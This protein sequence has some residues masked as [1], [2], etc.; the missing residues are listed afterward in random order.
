MDHYHRWQEDVALMREIGL[1]A[2]RMSIAWSRV[3]P[4]GKGALNPKGIAYYDRLIDA[5]LDA[6]IRP[7]VTL[8]HYDIPQVLE[9]QGGWWNR[10]LTNWFAEYAGQMAWLYGDRVTH[11]MTINRGRKILE[12]IFDFELRDR[13]GKKGGK[14]DVN[15][16]EGLGGQR[17]SLAIIAFWLVC[18]SE[19]GKII[20]DI[21]RG[22]FTNLHIPHVMIP[23]GENIL[24]TG[25]YP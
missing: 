3:L 24:V 22:Y 11:W 5:L 25:D 14:R 9:D 6:G 18:G 20:R 21:R 17:M 13:L 23:F 1:N 19:I 4:D 8:C 7:F 16:P 15:I 2:Y 10:E 12:R